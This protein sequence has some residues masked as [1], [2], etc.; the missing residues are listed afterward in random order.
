MIMG[1][2]VVDNIRS[3]VKKI[4]SLLEE[5]FAN[6]AIHRWHNP[7]SDGFMFLGGNFA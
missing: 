5:L 4:R 3:D 7:N 6:S 2:T 1:G